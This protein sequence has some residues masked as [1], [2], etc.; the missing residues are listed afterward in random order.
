MSRIHLLPQ[1]K[2]YK[3]NLHCHT[4]LSDGRISAEEMLEAYK[5]HGYSVIAFTDHEY[6]VNHQELA[7]DDMVVLTGYELAVYDGDPEKVS[8]R[9][10][11]CCHLNFY[12]KDPDADTHICFEPKRLHWLT[13][14][15]ISKI[16]YKGELCERKYS[17]LQHYIDEAKKEGFIVCLN[18]P[19]WSMQPREDY[20]HLKGLFAMEVFNSGGSA[21]GN[22]NPILSANLWHD[23][24]AA[25]NEGMDVAP[26]AADDNHNYNGD[27]E[28]S[29]S[30]HGYTMICTDDLSYG[31]VM[32]ALEEQRFYATTGIDIN[33]VSVEDG[34][35]YVKC[36]ECTMVLAFFGGIRWAWTENENGLKEAEL[37]VPEDARYIRVMCFDK[38]NGCAATTKAYRKEEIK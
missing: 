9:D 13:K 1:A 11:K 8:W 26:I 10:L 19:Y 18:H 15:E 37:S 36:S 14:E 2:Q 32:K 28:N 4:T 27:I 23:Y 12:A 25:I 6:I 35:L 22:Y 5:R 38:R 17:D 20:V 31:G 16:K 3:A 33:E 34:K 24:E 21:L 7:S 29:D 30:F